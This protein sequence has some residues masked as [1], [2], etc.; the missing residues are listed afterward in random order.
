MKKIFW[1]FTAILTCGI[2][3][4]SCSVDDIPAGSDSGGSDNKNIVE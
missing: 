3:L 4:I 2:S 1:I